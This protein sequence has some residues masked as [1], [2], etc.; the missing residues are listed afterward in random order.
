MKNLVKAYIM[1]V[2][3]LL[4]VYSAYAGTML[5]W[6]ASTGT[7][8]GYRI[9]YGISSGNYTG[10]EEA[11]NVTQYS[12]TNLPLQEE[13]TYYFVVR[14]YNDAGESEPSNEV[15]Y[16]CP[17]ST[18]PVPPQ[19]LSRQISGTSIILSWTANTESDLAGYN[20]YQGTSAGIYGTPV[21]LGKVITST[22]SGLTQGST[23]YFAVSA[24]DDA[25]NESGYSSTVSATIPDSTAPAVTITSPTS[26]STYAT[27]TATITLSGTA[28]DSTG[29]TTVTWANAA[30]G[31]SGTA[32]GTTSWSKSGISLASG[33]NTITITASDSTGNSASDILTVT[34]TPPDTTAPVVAITSPTSSSTYATS[35]A[36]ITLSGTASDSIGVTTVA[37]ANAANG[38][39]GTATGTTSWSISSISLAE[40]SNAIAVTASDS[41]GNMASATLTVTYSVPKAVADTTSPVVTIKSPTSNIFYSTRS[42][43]VKLTG[44]ASDNVGVTKV[45]WVNSTN[46]TS[47]T[48]TGTT[49]WT[50]SKIT[51]KT[52]TNVVK[53]TAQD[54]V[55]NISIDT[56]T[57]TRRR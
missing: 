39:S 21:S 1:I 42:S 3:L 6:D 12:L 46:G 50:V 5:T 47:G 13:T 54:A 57:I 33:S 28:S 53:I 24:L 22:I 34:Y 9:Y 37:W 14:A 4:S 38:T 8:T 25:A 18:P 43:S 32:T 36:T 19:G 40:G 15:T 41:A 49:R 7:V 20:V 35:T 17:D 10:I 56:L 2:V 51:L 26:S 48:A 45:T 30:N 52:G 29:V 44:T 11:G 16:Y 27:S 23:Y 31:T 55:G